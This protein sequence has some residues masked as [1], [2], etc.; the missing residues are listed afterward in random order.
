MEGSAVDAPATMNMVAYPNP[1]HDKLNVKFNSN[2]IDKY[3]L[4]LIDIT[5]RIMM[6]EVNTAQTGD[7][8]IEL[9]LSNYAEGIYTISLLTT[10][11]SKQVRIV[12][13]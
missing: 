10:E 7:N 6:N 13:N 3:I 1:V 5:G 12:V 11:G 4:Q 2:N 9:D 8:F